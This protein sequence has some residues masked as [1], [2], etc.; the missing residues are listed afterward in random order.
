[1]PSAATIA[2]ADSVPVTRNYVP[3]S[4]AGLVASHADVTTA[5]TPA[6]QSTFSLKLKP[7][8]NV[9]A[10]RVNLTFAL[11]IEY[12][13]STTGL[14]MSKDTFRASVEWVVP[15]MSTVLQRANFEA[16]VRNLIGHA[17]VKGYVTS[18]DAE[19]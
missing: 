10:R 1:M 5:G 2:I 12:T 9:S 16:L 19:Y 14:V 18:G 3:S 13:D 17:T 4:I 11:P 7:A 8:T 15:P 6:G